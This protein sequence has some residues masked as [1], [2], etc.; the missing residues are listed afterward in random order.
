MFVLQRAAPRAQVY[1]D[2]H[3]GYQQLPR[4]HSTVRH[5]RGEYVRGEVHTQGIES[6]WALFKRGHKGVYH[7]MSPKHLQR[8][9]N[10]FT[11]RHNMRD[12]DTRAQMSLI[13]Q[14]LVGKRLL[15][16]DLVG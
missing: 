16:K 7:K 10:E 15:Y 3:S 6:H 8:Y 2:E 11:G 13:A 4:K 9:V 14:R 5:S 12:L 1:T